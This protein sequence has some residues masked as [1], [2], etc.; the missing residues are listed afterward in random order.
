MRILALTAIPLVLALAAAA[1]AAER[2]VGTGQPYATIQAAVD[3]A[4]DGDAVIVH[5]GT[6]AEHVI[7][8]RRLSLRSLD[9]I[10]HGENDGAVIDGGGEAA[11]AVLVVADGVTVEGFTLYGATGL[12]DFAFYA[13]IG[14]VG[15]ANAT[16]AHNRSGTS[17]QQTS[18]IGIAARYADGL[19]ITGN[20]PAY[21]TNG[22]WL[23]DC[24]GATITANEPHHFISD[25]AGAGIALAGADVKDV[26]S[27]SHNRIAGNHVH[28]CNLGIYLALNATNNV[29]ADNLVENGFVG[30]Y[31]KDGSHYN[32]ISGNTVRGCNGRGIEVNNADACT[33]VGNLLEDDI[34]GIWLGY[35]DP[36]DNGADRCLVVGNTFTQNTTAGLRVSSHSLDT[37][38]FLN[39][40]VTNTHHV[41]SEGAEWA[42]AM[43]VSYVHG[44]V[45]HAGQL[46]N[47]YDTYGGADLDGDGV[48]D[49]DLPFRDGDAIYGPFEN[50]PLVDDPTAYALQAW[51]LDGGA[52]PLM[53]HADPAREIGERV[54][55]AGEAA[56]WLSAIVAA[57][58]LDY[59]SGAWAGDLRFAALPVDG[60]LLVEVGTASG[61]GDFMASGAEAAVA[62]DAWDAN[63][64]TSAAP[65]AVPVGAHLAL[66]ITNRS[67]VACAI[68]VGGAASLV[69]SPG[70]DDPVW[71]GGTIA[72][73]D[74]PR[75]GA[76]LAQNRPNPFNPSTTIAFALASPAQVDLLVYDL[77]GRLVRTLLRG[78]DLGGGEHAVVWTGEDDHGHAMASGAYLYRLVTPDG[79]IARCML[80]VR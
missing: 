62:A 21:G 60:D 40:F 18:D 69:S 80:L 3:A 26:S 53:H 27:A 38:V 70:L 35:L 23:E 61:A 11:Y 5:D 15:A 73:P 71:P 48:G 22:I 59:A 30:I 10:D 44:G 45:D 41:R 63:F 51:F 55:P 36:V 16:I 77:A 47:A 72:V 54:L 37:R 7:V 42:T 78:T 49:T 46:G 43:P 66:R 34:T 56:T 6:Y 39:A 74:T 65:V 52:V 57:D 32:V 2:H 31:A 50:H 75:A 68:L 4:A 28:N 33:L 13:S 76:R 19:V 58:D 79:A 29:I 9:F 8:D 24:R 17:Y 20:E 64:T 12:A 1:A 25:P 67:P 14:V